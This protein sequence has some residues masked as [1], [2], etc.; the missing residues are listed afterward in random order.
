M[1]LRPAVYMVLT[2]AGLLYAPQLALAQ[3][4]IQAPAS[5]AIGTPKLDQAGDGAVAD[6]HER[7]RR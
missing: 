6:C 2:V 1:V 7:P 5:K 4:A 3:V